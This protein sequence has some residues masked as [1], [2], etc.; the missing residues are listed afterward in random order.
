MCIV[1]YFRHKECKHTWGVITEP[2]GPGMG[3]STCASFGSSGAVK[4]TPK[5]YKTKSRPCP[6]CELKAGY[7]CNVLRMVKDMGWGL[8]WGVGLDEDDWG[9]QVTMGKGCTML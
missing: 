8:K 7:D 9:F 3:F 4:A 6:R 5:L 2:C 1:M